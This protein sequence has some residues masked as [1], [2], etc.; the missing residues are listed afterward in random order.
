MKSFKRQPTFILWQKERFNGFEE[1][2]SPTENEDDE[3]H[4]TKDGTQIHWNV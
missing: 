1:T 2:W 4:I 3:V